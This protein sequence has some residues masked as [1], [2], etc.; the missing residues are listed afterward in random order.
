M[1][2]V[3]EETASDRTSIVFI[4]TLL[5]AA[6]KRNA[7]PWMALQAEMRASLVIQR[8]RVPPSGLSEILFCKGMH[9]VCC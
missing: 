5:S 6:G 1:V 9:C 3:R 7:G 2:S 8:N 4:K